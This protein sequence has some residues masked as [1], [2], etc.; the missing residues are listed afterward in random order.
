MSNKRKL[1]K[2]PTGWSYAKF[3]KVLLDSDLDED[4]KARLAVRAAY[5]D[6]KGRIPDGPHPPL[7]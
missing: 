2:P 5:A 7:R 3:L 6:R 4:E 1:K